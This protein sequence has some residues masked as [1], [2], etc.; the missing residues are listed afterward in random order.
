MIMRTGESGSAASAPREPV[1]STAEAAPAAATN[2]LL[3]ITIPSLR[4]ILLCPEI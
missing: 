1:A 3:V 4:V 2:D